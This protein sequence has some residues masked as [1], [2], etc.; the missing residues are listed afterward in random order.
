ME[1]TREC[2]SP[3]AP[4]AQRLRFITRASTPSSSSCRWLCA[5]ASS[6]RS[7]RLA[8]DY[9]ST[10]TIGSRGRIDTELALAT[11]GSFTRSTWSRTGFICSRSDIAG[12]FTDRKRLTMHKISRSSGKHRFLLPVACLSIYPPRRT[13]DFGVARQSGSKQRLCAG[14]AKLR[15]RDAAATTF[16]A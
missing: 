16:Q 3:D 6:R 9:Q 7:T 14:A 4:W 1:R 8:Y 10:H 13:K 2:V 5:H 11:I 15:L 12:K